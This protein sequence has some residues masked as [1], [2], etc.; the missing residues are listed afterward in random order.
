[1]SETT[2]K[3]VQQ[4]SV[5]LNALRAVIQ[6]ER[7][8][9]SLDKITKPSIV[10][11]VLAFDFSH[12]DSLS[13]SDLEKY[14]GALS[15]YLIYINK[16]INEISIAAGAVQRRYDY[17]LNQKILAIKKGGQTV[18]EKTMEAESDPDVLELSRMLEKFQA[19]VAMYKNIPDA[20]EILVQTI[21]KVYDSRHKEGKHD[22]IR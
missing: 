14:L 12:I 20:I 9:T 4:T 18:K 15:Q 6:E 16:Y 1:M 3:E 21:K 5:A 19:R 13:N 7:K 22:S 17:V 11:D 10:E 8:S 2:N